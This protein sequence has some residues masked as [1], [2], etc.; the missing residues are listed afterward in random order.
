MTL[1]VEIHF[2]RREWRQF[3]WF[4]T[5]MFL[6]VGFIAGLIGGRSWG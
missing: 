4:L 2:N 5:G 6:V 1:P 3:R